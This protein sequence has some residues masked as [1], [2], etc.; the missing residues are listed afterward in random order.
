MKIKIVDFEVI[1]PIWKEKLWKDRNTK[2]EASNPIDYLGR[3]NPR[4]LD[5]KPTCIACFHNNEIVGVNSLLPTSDLFCRSRGLY[6]N[7]EQRLKGVGKKLMKQTFE[8]AKEM[9]FKFIWSLPR[10]SA[11]AFYLSCGFEQT[12]EFDDQYEFGPNCFILKKIGE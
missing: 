2:I 12:S 11:L 10:K 7:P 9:S 3:Y 5:N 1:L 4:I 8:I 6:V